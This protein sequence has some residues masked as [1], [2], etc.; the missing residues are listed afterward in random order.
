MRDSIG[1][2]QR[3]VDQRRSGFA[4]RP[5]PTVEVK[6]GIAAVRG[7][8]ILVQSKYSSFVVQVQVQSPATVVVGDNYPSGKLTTRISLA[9]EPRLNMACPQ[10]DLVGN[11]SR[12]LGIPALGY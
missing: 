10:H 4:V 8:G 11:W 6:A 2:K 9:A 3:S 1:S 12:R 7:L 5:G